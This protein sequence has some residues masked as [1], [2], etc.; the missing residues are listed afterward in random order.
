MK[1]EVVS[2]EQVPLSS[3]VSYKEVWSQVEQLEKGNSL[4]IELEDAKSAAKAQLGLAAR[5]R[6][7]T[8]FKVRR[9]G[10]T[11]WVYREDGAA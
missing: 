3:R 8:G 1:I 11:V 6:S 5:S 10:S 9:K 7:S 2:V 4:K